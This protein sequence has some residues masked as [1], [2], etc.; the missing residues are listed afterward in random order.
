MSL[1][2]LPNG[3][4]VN[5]EYVTTICDDPYVGANGRVNRTSLWV[6]GN[7]GYGTKR[8]NFGGETYATPDAIAGII[9]RAHKEDI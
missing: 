7:E 6:I 4:W 1:V 2:K 5:P 8:Y 3:A 9:N